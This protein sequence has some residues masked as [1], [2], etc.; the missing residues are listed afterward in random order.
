MKTARP[1]RVAKHSDISSSPIYVLIAIG[2]LDFGIFIYGNALWKANVQKT[3]PLLDNVARAKVNISA[4]HLWFEEMIGGDQTVTIEYVFELFNKSI[5]VLDDA[6]KGESNIEGIKGKPVIDI[7]LIDNIQKMK[8]LIQKFIDISNE[9]F[10]TQD[11][12]GIGS[13]LDQYYDDVYREIIAE[14][15]V[16]DSIVHLQINHSLRKMKLIQIII[17]SLWSIIITGTGSML[18]IATRKRRHAEEELIKYQCKLED[19]VA[20]RTSELE[21]S[22]REKE[23]L[24]KE[25]H[26]RVKNNMQV[27]ISLL[28]MQSRYVNDKQCIDMFKE[29]QSRIESMAIVH[30]KFYQSKDLSNVNFKDYVEDIVRE[31][32]RSYGVDTGK[33]GRK[34]EVADVSLGINTAI[35][36]GL[37]INE[38]ISNSLKHAFPAGKG[39][40]MLIQLHLIDPV[41]SSEAGAKQV[42][43]VDQDWI[44]LIVSDTGVGMPENI[45]FRNTKSLGLQMITGIVENQLGGTIEVGRTEGTRIQIRFKKT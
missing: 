32:F 10:R 28:K 23:V 35:P 9:R 30:E 45:D 37:V 40:E 2:I 36:C 29:C 27:I 41:E 20:E 17:L 19:R 14:A 31:L 42:H 39:G 22:L 44:E 16:I 25:V 18:F 4:G 5:Q 38:L 7:K 8:S 1:K 15:N 12:S 13:R 6:L 34:I 26:H 21:I 11:V 43:R 33:I 24:L 3:A